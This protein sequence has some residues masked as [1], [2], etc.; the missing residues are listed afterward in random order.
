MKRL[1]LLLLIVTF[2][3]IC[4]A[5]DFQAVDGDTV[6]IDGEKVHLRGIDAPELDQPCGEDAKNAVTLMLQTGGFEPCKISNAG[7]RGR[8]GDFI[9]KNGSSMA[10]TLVSLGL[11]WSTDPKSMIP[12]KMQKLMK[13]AQHQKRWIWAENNPVNPADWRKNPTRYTADLRYLAENK[14]AKKLQRREDEARQ[15]AEWNHLVATNPALAQQIIAAK[16]QEA[17]DKKLQKRLRN[18]EIQQII[19][20]SNA[21]FHMM[22]MNS[23]LR[24]IDNSLMGIRMGF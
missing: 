7:P 21:E 24:S 3:Q 8:Y 13:K 10:E 22:E 15:L 20:N 5:Q 1:F 6:L 12:T 23:S 4:S 19:N 11:A 9:T 14:Y 2:T 16:E 17:R 18:M